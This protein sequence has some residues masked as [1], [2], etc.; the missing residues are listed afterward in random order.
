M[1]VIL[2]SLLVSL[3]LLS[4]AQNTY[5]LVGTYTNGKSVGVYVYDFNEANGTAKVVDS[6]TTQNPSYLAVSPNQKFVYAVNEKNN[7]DKNGGKVSAFAFDRSTGHL[8]LLN[9]QPSMGDDP[10]YISIDKTGKWA[11]VANYSSGTF[12]I[13]P[14]NADGA[15]GAPSTTITDSGHGTNKERQEGPHVHSTVIS[16]DNRYLFVA[17]L[18]TDKE[19]VYNFNDKNGKI[20]PFQEPFAKL[21]DGSGPRHFVLHPSG[22]WAYVTQEL[23]GSVTAFDYANGKLKQI[24]TLGTL[25]KDYKGPLGTADIHVSPD[26][27][28]LYV[29]DRGNANTI[30]IMKIDQKTGMLTMVGHESTKGLTPRNF[31]F[32]PSGNY[33]LVAN[34]N[35]DN[36][37]VFKVNRQT[38]MLTYTG[39]EIKVGNPVCVKWIGR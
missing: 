34:Q 18:G 26:G 32:D 10:C 30:A 39:N 13:L 21:Q 2:T 8:K 16:P 3:C 20:K 17:D 6:I 7:H 33:M 5:M 28:F 19:S 12:S 9:Q 24:Q 35:S 37:V 27:K 36:I 38:G 1:K 4:F 15:L 14:I 29:S 25:P 11:A 31:N 23:S 22:K